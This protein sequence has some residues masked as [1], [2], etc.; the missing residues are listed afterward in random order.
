MASWIIESAI[1]LIVFY[2]AYILF[3]KKVGFF[4]ANRL[5]LL[6]AI[7]FSLVMPYIR[8][9]PPVNTVTYSWFIPEVTVTGNMAELTPVSEGSE[10]TLIKSFLAV[11]LAGAV[12]LFA[13]L[14]MRLM[15]LYVLTRWNGSKRRGNAR[16]VSF[17]SGQSP[18]SFFNCIF[19]NESLYSEEEKERII[20]HE[21]A[22]IGQYHT[23]DLI[24]LELL[25]IIQWFN[26]AAWLYRR[27]MLEIHEYLADEEV[28]K[29]GV[30]IPVYQEMLMKLQLGREFFSP[31]NNFNKSLT[32]N[33][34]RMMTRIKPPAWERIRFFILIP[35][36]ALLVFT[37]TKN[38]GELSL[39]GDT[40][41]PSIAAPEALPFNIPEGEVSTTSNESEIFFIVEDMPDFLGGGQDRFRQHIVNNLRYPQAAAEKGIEGRVFVQF[42]VNEDGT[43]SDA[44]V[45]R[46]VDPSLDREAIRVVMSSPRWTPGRQRGEPVRVAFTFPINFVLAEP[47]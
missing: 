10:F 30:S 26:P 4:R 12:I 44:T 2:L 7:I 19:I 46:G 16:I 24:L 31:A 3:L 22:H 23:L 32:L 20:E 15:Q 17:S 27:S 5:Y 36:L 43:V 9:A 13:R 34:V 47:A 41:E 37:C 39:E 28:I 45:V 33:R 25:I 40:F 6:T 8:I 35:F 14:F 38:G 18:F 29:K 21:M 11:Y 1:S 42:V